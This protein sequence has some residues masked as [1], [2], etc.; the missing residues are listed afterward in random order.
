MRSATKEVKPPVQ[1][2]DQPRCAEATARLEKLKPML[3]EARKR[4]ETLTG[5][6]RSEIKKLICS[7]ALRLMPA[8][9]DAVADDMARKVAESGSISDSLMNRLRFGAPVNTLR[10]GDEDLTEEFNVVA[11]AARSVELLAR[12][13][14]VQERS[15]LA[16]KKLAIG[17]ACESTQSVRSRIAREVADAFLGLAIKLSEENAIIGGLR[18]QDSSI[19]GLLRPPPFP[20]ALHSNQDV[21]RWLAAVLEISDSEVQAR[22]S[23]GDMPIAS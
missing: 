22:M 7:S 4:L 6:A 18:E 19:P 23:Q 12:A 14:K 15:V 9:T 13:V 17:A 21:I 8:T 2:A 20:I 10:V 16:E 5:R 3:A 11:D 1:I